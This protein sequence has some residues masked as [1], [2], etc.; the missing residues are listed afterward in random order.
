MP[1]RDLITIDRQT[2]EIL[3]GMSV[4][5]G[6][7]PISIYGH[8][9]FQMSQDP[10]LQIAKDKELAGRPM[11]VLIYLL[12]RLDF[13]NYIQVPQAE[14]VHALE[15]HHS[16]VSRSISLL[17]N[18]G[19]LIRGPKTGRSFTFRLNPTYGWKGKAK[20][21]SDAQRETLKA[22]LEVIRGKPNEEGP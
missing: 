17:E 6:A 8:R 5:I 13:E 19:I 22:Q 4:W 3:E 15:L 20:N 14:I 2:G 12:A 10:L 9:W 16:D 7:K 1:K 18:K 11:R 21:A